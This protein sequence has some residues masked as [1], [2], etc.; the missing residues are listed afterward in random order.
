MIY[1]YNYAGQPWKTQHWVREV[2]NRLYKPTP[3]GYCGDE[4][5]GQTSAWYVFSA[6]GFYPVCPGVDQ[7]VLGTPLFSKV[8]LKLENGQQLVINAPGSTD[9]KRYVQSLQWNGKA[10]SKNWLSHSELLKGGALNF[11]LGATPNKQRG[12]KV[13]DYP[14]SMTLHD[15]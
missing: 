8:T 6:M 1:L 14:Y 10:H 9:Q 12:T 2:M 11:T 3:D 4:D 7:Y 5:N 15:K 13:E